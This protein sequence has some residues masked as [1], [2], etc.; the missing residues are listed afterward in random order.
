MFAISSK[1]SSRL[2]PLVPIEYLL[3]R[4]KIVLNNVCKIHDWNLMIFKRYLIWSITALNFRGSKFRDTFL[5]EL[6]PLKFNSRFFQIMS[7]NLRKFHIIVSFLKIAKH[8]SLVIS[9][10]F[11]SFLGH[12][13]KT[14][15]VIAYVPSI[16]FWCFRIAPWPLQSPFESQRELVPYTHSGLAVLSSELLLHFAPRIVDLAAL[17]LLLCSYDSFYSPFSPFFVVVRSSKQLGVH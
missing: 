9:V 15:W 10:W 6:A 13:E 1:I 5:L 11:V 3:A 8:W 7:R 16:S 4:K 2:G 12:S 17:Q 14:F